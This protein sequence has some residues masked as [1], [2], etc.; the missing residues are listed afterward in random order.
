[1]AK[2]LLIPVLPSDRFYDAVVAAADLLASEGGLITFL[3]TEVR[4][5]DDT[6]AEDTTGHPSD[7]DVSIESGEVDARDV[8][9]W[10]DKQIAALEDARQILYER[11]VNDDRIDYAFA[12]FA[13]AES[14]AQAIADEAAAGAYDL[15]VL[16][17]GYLED[18]VDDQGSSPTEILDTIKKSVGDEVGIMVA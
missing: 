4:P 11:G 2:K 14:A 10:R 3:F 1:M 9:R 17:R 8:E 7:L 15:V 6:Y 13:D 16:A 12:D 5:S 18:E